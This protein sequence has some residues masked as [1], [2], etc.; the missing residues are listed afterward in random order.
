MSLSHLLL[1]LGIL[2]E[3]CRSLSLERNTVPLTLHT[4]SGTALFFK[5]LLDSGLTTEAAS[6][7][8]TPNGTPLLA[9]QRYELTP[10]LEWLS[11]IV[12]GLPPTYLRTDSLGPTLRIV[13][14]ELDY[15]HTLRFRLFHRDTTWAITGLDYLPWRRPAIPVLSPADE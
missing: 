4:P 2:C 10:E 14:L 15:L 3:G 12:R 8:A 9:E 11:Q 13:W 6:L 7:F 1:S 5:A